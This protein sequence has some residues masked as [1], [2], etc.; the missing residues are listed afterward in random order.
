MATVALIKNLICLD[1]QP[2]RHLTGQDNKDIEAKP[3]SWLFC[4]Q[5]CF[6][7]LAFASSFEIP[8]SMNAK[9]HNL[10]NSNVMRS[11]FNR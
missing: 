7:C 6:T 1:S 5:L 4:L 9:L 2:K 10:V 3:A 11:F 8:G